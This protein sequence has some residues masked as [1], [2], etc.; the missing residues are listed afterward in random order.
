MNK[1]TFSVSKGILA[2]KKTMTTQILHYNLEL[3]LYQGQS[4]KSDN[5]NDIVLGKANRIVCLMLY[6][7]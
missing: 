5:V 4:T 2:E 6:T 7:C 1:N 3:H